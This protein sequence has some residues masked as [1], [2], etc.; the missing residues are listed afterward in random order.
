MK[1]T[2]SLVGSGRDILELLV[3]KEG[4]TINLNHR[5]SKL[6]GTQR[7]STNPYDFG[8]VAFKEFKDRS[9]VSIVQT[10]KEKSAHQRGIWML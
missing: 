9:K 8:R 3:D 1:T 5:I 10:Q 4:N 7:S 6:E 2:G